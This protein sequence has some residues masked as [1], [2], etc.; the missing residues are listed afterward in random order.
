[1][2]SGEHAFKFQPSATTQ[3]HTTLVQ[4]EV[5]TGL[6]SF[7]VAPTWSMGKQTQAGFEGFNRELKMKVEGEEK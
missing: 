4:E 3:G 6:L 2:F 5:F 1:M 7:L